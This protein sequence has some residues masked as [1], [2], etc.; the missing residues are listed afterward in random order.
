MITDNEQMDSSTIDMSVRIGSMVMPNPVTVASGTFG[1][2]EEY[3]K[4]FDVTS[5][6]RSW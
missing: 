1:Y 6:G 4:L 3:S 5:S 2:G